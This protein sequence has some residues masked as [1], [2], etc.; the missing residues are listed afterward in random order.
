MA[1]IIFW[2]SIFPKQFTRPIACY[3]L[4][5][6]LRKN[7]LS[8]Q[9]I[10]FTG[11]FSTKELIE[12]TE[13]FIEKETMALGIATGFW[14]D[15]HVYL[16]DAITAFKDKYP[17][18]QIFF[19]GPRANNPLY[20]KYYDMVF[21]GESEN[22]LTDW[23]YEKLEK[24]K[25][26]ITP[27]NITKLDHRFTKQDC[28]LNNEV[29]PIELGRGCIFK[30]KFCSHSNLGKPK[31]TYQRNF[32]LV[33]EEIRYNYD[34]FNTTNYLF[35]DDTVNEDLDKVKA[36]ADINKKM[37]WVI[38]WNGYLRADLI[39]SMKDSANYLLDSGLKSCFF[40]I[41]SFHKQASQVIGKGWSGK[42]AKEFLPN[43]YF[44]HWH[45]EISIWNNFIIG[46]PYETEYDIDQSVKWCIENNFG[47][48]KFVGLNLYNYREDSGPKSE[49]TVNY[50]S[51]G[52]TINETGFYNDNWDSNKIYRK[53]EEVNK[54][55]E[56]YNKLT[57]W[58]LF[59]A[60]NITKKDINFLKQQPVDYIS[61][62]DLFN[63]KNEYKTKLLEL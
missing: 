45:K 31:Y 54:L 58:S 34:N 61:I 8:A 32:K 3:Q 33:E 42:H 11:L 13:K 9:V 62:S 27:F 18:I 7:N 4:A 37:N 38:N 49:F 56:P 44:N 24:D 30:C 53:V 43:L 21:L 60:V 19:G 52:Y 39:W 51:Y 41:E 63:F 16:K 28:I 23:L 36:L 1:N 47:M 55:I 17:N 29:L 12:I 26:Y 50:K 59:D 20:K 15:N 22:S 40:G 6:H 57:S 10:D 14:P 46:L 35:L 25:S 2:S 48:N 5:H